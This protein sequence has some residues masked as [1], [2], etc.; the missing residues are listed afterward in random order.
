MKRLRN[1]L[2]TR[3]VNGRITPLS[4]DRRSEP[5]VEGQ[6]SMHT[7]SVQSENIDFSYGSNDDR[8][9]GDL[10][11]RSAVWQAEHFVLSFCSARQGQ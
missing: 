6:L 9:M 3:V 8:D 1:V 2:V 7:L 5:N 10:I 4:D 11:L